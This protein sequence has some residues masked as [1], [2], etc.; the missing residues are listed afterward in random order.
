MNK[1]KP[2]APKKEEWNKDTDEFQGKQE[3]Q[4]DS[5]AVFVVICCIITVISSLINEAILWLSK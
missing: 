3:H 4:R 1:N 5:F 2:L